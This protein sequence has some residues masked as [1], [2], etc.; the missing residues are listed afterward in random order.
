MGLPMYDAPNAVE[1]IEAAEETSA[2]GK[3]RSDNGGT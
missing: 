1:R 2:E 3:G